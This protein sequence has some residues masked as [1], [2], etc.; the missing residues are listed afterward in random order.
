MR[1]QVPLYLPL[2]PLLW[3]HPVLCYI[4]LEIGSLV[5]HYVHSAHPQLLIQKKK[6]L[7]ILT[8]YFYFQFSE[9]ELSNLLSIDKDLLPEIFILWRLIVTKEAFTRAHM[10]IH[11]YSYMQTAS[12]QHPNSLHFFSLQLVISI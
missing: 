2:S 1:T 9:E 11:L 4:L 7:K 3:I 8:K 12:L 6:S 10:C 5:L